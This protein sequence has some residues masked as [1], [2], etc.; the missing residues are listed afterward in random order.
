MAIE[1]PGFRPAGFVA[2]ADLSAKQ[3]RFV[4]PTSTDMNVNACS[5]AGEGA[6]GVL[7]NS[8]S[9]GQEAEVMI[10]GVSKVEA[11]ETLVSG[12]YVGTDNQ[13]RAVKIDH[14]ATGAD[15]GS[16]ILGR[17]VL[18]GGS[19]EFVSVILAGPVGYRVTA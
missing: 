12:D 1:V 14:T 11:A 6:I 16:F 3:Y 15:N 9:Q 2:A 17:C 13:G 4:K 18:G 8:P 7:Q 5:V 10:S 19:G